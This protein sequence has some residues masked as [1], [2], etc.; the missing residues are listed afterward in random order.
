M[1]DFIMKKKNSEDKVKG[2]IEMATMT[3]PS[4]FEIN[5]TKDNY[6]EVC[7]KINEPRMTDDFIK[8][9]FR[10]SEELRKNNDT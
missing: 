10:V 8:E 3:K 1:G 2:V 9:C 5:T 7:K 4:V 6:D